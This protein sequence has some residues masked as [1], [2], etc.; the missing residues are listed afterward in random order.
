MIKIEIRKIDL[1]IFNFAFCK[2]CLNLSQEVKRE[3]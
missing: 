1:R 2:I 3:P